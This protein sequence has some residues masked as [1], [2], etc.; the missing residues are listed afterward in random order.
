MSQARIIAAERVKGATKE[1]IAL[2]ASR[3]V[4][5]RTS[6][7]SHNEMVLFL[8]VGTVE[9]LTGPQQARGRVSR[10][11]R[12]RSPRIAIT[13][14]LLLFISN[15]WFWSSMASCPMGSLY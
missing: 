3:N 1:T 2:T 7:S 12:R 10:V 8:P 4:T 14:R 13:T 15:T 11:P 6:G 9:S 5:K